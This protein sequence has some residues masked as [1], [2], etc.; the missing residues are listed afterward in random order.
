MPKK[1]APN[2]RRTNGARRTKVIQRVRREESECWLCGEPVDVT[3]PPRL[4]ASPEIHEIIPV[5]RGGDPYDRSNCHLTHRVCNQ[6]QGNRL[7]DEEIAP[8]RTSS[9]R[10]E[11]SRTW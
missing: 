3:L 8:S 10:I 9:S 1:P 6:K 11:T 5:S 2:P 7:P 4:P